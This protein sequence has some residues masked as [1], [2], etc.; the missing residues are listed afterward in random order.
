MQIYKCI[1]NN[2]SGQWGKKKAIQIRYFPQSTHC[3]KAPL[4]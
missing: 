4:K 2:H 1:I 3:E